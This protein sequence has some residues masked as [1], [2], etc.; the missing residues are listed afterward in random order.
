MN[1]EFHIIFAITAYKIISLLIGTAFAFMG[2]RLFVSGIWGDAGEVEATFRDNKLLIKRGAPGTFFA[3][4]GTIIVC[5]VIFTKLEFQKV[6]SG[7]TNNSPIN[8]P[9][10]KTDE[11]PDKLPL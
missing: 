5:S 2:Y 8:I 9:I 3:V 7:E 6:T 1:T 4:F 10:D 11:L